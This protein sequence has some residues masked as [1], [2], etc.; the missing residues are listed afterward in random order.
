MTW[1]KY[2]KFFNPRVIM[3]AWVSLMVSLFLLLGHV[4]DKNKEEV[5][6]IELY[7]VDLLN[8]DFEIVRTFT[9]KNWDITEND[10]NVI[11]HLSDDWR[12]K[13][14]WTQGHRITKVTINKEDIYNNRY[15]GADT[16]RR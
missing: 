3:T 12:N 14:I 13:V 5:G 4:H 7:Q 8:D 16:K 10:D 6:T 2:N 15:R 9:V 1:P 11:I